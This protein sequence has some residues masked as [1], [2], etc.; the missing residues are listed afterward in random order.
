MGQEGL[1]KTSKVFCEVKPNRKPKVHTQNVIPNS[2]SPH[3]TRDHDFSFIVTHLIPSGVDSYLVS[4]SR[5][6]FEGTGID[7]PT[8]TQILHL[9]PECHSINKYLFQHVLCSSIVYKDQDFYFIDITSQLPNDDDD[10]HQVSDST[11]ISV[12]T[13][14]GSILHKSA[15]V[16][17]IGWYLF[18]H[19]Q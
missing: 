13:G 7:S 1:G 10:T 5:S 6:T 15:H 14:I 4:G 11:S 8:K 9:C 17:R 12:G 2:N 16:S 18:Q 3:I 19:M